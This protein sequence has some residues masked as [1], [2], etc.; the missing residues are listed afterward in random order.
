VITRFRSPRC[1]RSQLIP[2]GGPHFLPDEQ[3]SEGVAD[4]P[5]ARGQRNAVIDP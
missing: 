5:G 3:H 1:Q 2:R 4:E